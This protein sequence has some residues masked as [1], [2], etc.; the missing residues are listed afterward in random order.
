MSNKPMRWLRVA[1]LCAATGLAPAASGTSFS[2]NFS[3]LWWI[4][5]ESG[6]GANVTQQDDVMFVT[7]FVYG[8]SG[9]PVWYVATLEYAGANFAGE[10]VFTGDLYQTTGAWFGTGWN[11]LLYSVRR[12]G[13]AAFQAGEVA[14]A[15]L[16]Y[17]VDGVPVVK[18]VERQT[19][20]LDDYEGTYYGGT[21]DVTYGCSNPV[22][23][24]I[25]T[26]DSGQ[27]RITH[28]GPLITIRAPTCTFVGTYVQ[29]G[30][31]GRADTNYVC[32][33]NAT[34]V[35][36]FFDLRVET[37]GIVGRYDGVDLAC[38]FD[39]NIGGYRRK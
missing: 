31:L 33:N 24:G 22:N 37:S 19:L 23:N 39:G 30:Q 36:T 34:G 35:A 29:Q 32:T 2:T 16:S 4:R 5:N 8:A 14:R 28:N 9:Q 6:W 11:P 38:R 25:R 3:D 18:F 12:V 17:T 10:L 15:T 26:E 20:R 13:T 21:V 27:I 1:L 7:F